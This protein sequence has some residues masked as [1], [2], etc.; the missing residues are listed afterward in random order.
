MGIYDFQDLSPLRTTTN[1]YTLGVNLTT[2]IIDYLLDSHSN[3]RFT[4]TSINNHHTV[5]RNPVMDDLLWQVPT[6]AMFN[7]R[8]HHPDLVDNTL[9]LHIKTPLNT[10]FSPTLYHSITIFIHHW[11]PSDLY[12][13]QCPKSLHRKE[14]IYNKWNTILYWKI[15][16]SPNKVT[17]TLRP[18]NNLPRHQM[19]M[20][21]N[22][23]KLN[24]NICG[25]FWS[26]GKI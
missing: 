16:K 18:R 7:K 6:F 22:N 5:T 1:I 25:T 23:S 21:M 26:I 17:H 14:K 4:K 24:G 20:G 2:M 9:L 15:E 19:E 11:G 12:F 8:L 3:N 10:I 13:L